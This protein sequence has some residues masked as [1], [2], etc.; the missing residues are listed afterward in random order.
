MTQDDG[1]LSI[2]YVLRKYRIDRRGWRWVV[3]C[4]TTYMSLVGVQ[5]TKTCSF[6][7]GPFWSI[8]TALSVE[9][10]LREAWYDGMDAERSKKRGEGDGHS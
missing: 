6:C 8:R 2:K 3:A 10:A 1:G 4:D 7:C 9:A 5:K